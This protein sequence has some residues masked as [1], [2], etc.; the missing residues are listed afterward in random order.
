M[1]YK[2]YYC[3]YINPKLIEFLDTK[4]IQYKISGKC[5]MVD[6]VYFTPLVSFSLY[7]SSPETIE[8][9]DCLANMDIKDPI[10]TIEFTQSEINHAD[11][12]VMRP[13]RQKI[14]IINVDTAFVYSCTR[15]S[16]FGITRARHEYQ[17]GE[18]AIAK[19]PPMNT[20]TALWSSD[21]GFSEIYADKRVYDLVNMNTLCGIKF[22]KVFLKNGVYSDKLYQ[23][24]TENL[25]SREMID[26]GHGEKILKC[27]ICGKEQLYIDTSYQLYLKDFKT[28]SPSDFY[29][30]D[31]IFGDGRP[32][33]IYIISQRFYQL[34][35][36]N[37]LSKNVNF[38]PVIDASKVY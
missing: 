31:S 34:L 13:K 11:L 5:G 35:K 21:T 25:I 38:S 16:G 4:Q 2:Y 20:N 18:L 27:P 6:G 24:K 23:L 33:P 10:T 32:E 9:I 30:T 29:I 12:L 7:S 26:E 17:V 37:N 14:E 15:V 36:K 1:R 19:E 3:R 28:I 22:E 8:L